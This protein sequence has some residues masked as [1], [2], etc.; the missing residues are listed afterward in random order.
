MSKT[1]KY[2]WEEEVEPV[3]VPN[4]GKY[5]FGS[6]ENSLCNYN[7][8][9]DCFNKDKCKTCGWNP[10]VTLR[11]KKEFLEEMSKKWR[12]VIHTTKWE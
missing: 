12:Y 3:Y 5:K 11:R 4:T 9:V 10:I 2:E 6:L 7:D 8:A 1:G